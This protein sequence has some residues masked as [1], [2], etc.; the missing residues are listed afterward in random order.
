[1]LAVAESEPRPILTQAEA[2]Q[3]NSAN[4]TKITP[5]NA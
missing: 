1:M 4:A 5:T 3:P 2:E